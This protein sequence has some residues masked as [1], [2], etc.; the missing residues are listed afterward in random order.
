[1]PSTNAA[2]VTVGSRRRRARSTPG[3][4]SAP[5]L[6]GPDPQQAADV[7]VG[8]RAAAGADRAD[9]DPRR[10]HRQADD[11]CP[12]TCSCGR[13]PVI[14]HVSKLVPPT[15]AVITSPRSRSRAS[16]AAPSAP[17]T[18][19]G[20]DRLERPLLGLGERHRAAAGARDEQ[21]RRRSRRREAARRAAAGSAPCAGGR[22]R[23]SPSCV[24]RSY[25]RYS[26]ET[27]CESEISPSNPKL[28]QRPLGGELV[29]RVRVRS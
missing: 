4:G 1:M 11:A 27:R 21:A 18:G 12:R 22:R 7:D 29:R 25:S 26:P 10:L 5:A 23:R 28:A 16:S 2:S 20:H 3:P 9:V 13:P 24:V 14:R 6:R 17:A 15:S 8:D 19:P